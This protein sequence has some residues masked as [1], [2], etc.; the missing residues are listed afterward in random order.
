MQTFDFTKIAIIPAHCLWVAGLLLE[1]GSRASAGVPRLYRARHTAGNRLAL[2]DMVSGAWGA[3]DTNPL[4][5]MPA[6]L[7]SLWAGGNGSVAVNAQWNA[8]RVSIHSREFLLVGTFSQVGGASADPRP[9]VG[10]AQPLPQSKDGAH[11]SETSHEHREAF[12]G[13]GADVPSAKKVRFVPKLEPWS[14]TPA[15]NGV[16]STT[17]RPISF[18]RKIVTFSGATNSAR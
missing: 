13:G 18:C 11:S 5:E 15:G 17:G 10:P 8:N 6:R 12:T 3:P 16:N 1:S 4:Q 9:A 14:G 2:G 7:A